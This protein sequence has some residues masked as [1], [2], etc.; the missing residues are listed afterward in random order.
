VQALQ[1]E[2]HPPVHR[3]GITSPHPDLGEGPNINPSPPRKPWPSRDS[4]RLSSLPLFLGHRWS[5][6]L[7]HIDLF[8]GPCFFRPPVNPQVR[9]LA[10]LSFDSA[11]LF[12]DFDY[13]PPFGTFGSFG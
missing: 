1:G 4:L 5:I 3:P 13:R 10:F 12:F 2:C 8:P 7:F 11:V 6:A 9:N